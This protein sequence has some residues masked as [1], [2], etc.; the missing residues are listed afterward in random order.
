MTREAVAVRDYARSL[1]TGGH[2][3]MLLARLMPFAKQLAERL[4][5]RLRRSLL[6]AR[7]S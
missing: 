1:G 6:S 2:F 7:S 5:P 4:P 3:G